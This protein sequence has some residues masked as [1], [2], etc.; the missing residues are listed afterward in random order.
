MEANDLFVASTVEEFALKDISLNYI[1]VVQ[2]KE[3]VY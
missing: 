1:R 2:R 3:M